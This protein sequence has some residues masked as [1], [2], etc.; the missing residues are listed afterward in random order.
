MAKTEDLK[1]LREAVTPEVTIIG[2]KDDG[3][4]ILAEIRHH[5]PQ[6]R[7]GHKFPAA[8]NKQTGEIS[9]GPGFFDC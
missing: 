1:K 3:K 8:M 5:Y 7:L 9:V 6:L 4:A 2:M